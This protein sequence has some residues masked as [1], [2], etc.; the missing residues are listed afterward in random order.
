LPPGSQQFG[1]VVPVRASDGISR[2]EG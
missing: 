2:Q 1:D